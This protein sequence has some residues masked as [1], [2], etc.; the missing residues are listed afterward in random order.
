MKPNR[1][2][3][4]KICGRTQGNQNWVRQWW[5]TVHEICLWSIA[6]LEPHSQPFI[7]MDLKL[8]NHKESGNTASN[9]GTWL[10]I[11][12]DML[13]LLIP[14]PLN[15]S[16]SKDSTSFMNE[17][18]TRLH[19]DARVNDNVKTSDFSCLDNRDDL[20]KEIKSLILR[21]HPNILHE[22]HKNPTPWWWCKS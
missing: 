14:L 18:G 10:V 11:E 8:T 15:H 1:S 22:G 3:L 20:T 16:S 12:S 17:I 2:V 4:D 6:A 13:R 5:N 21:N 19:D 9:W 7:A